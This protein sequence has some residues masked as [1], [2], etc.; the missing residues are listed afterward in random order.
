MEAL[1]FTLQFLLYSITTW[2]TMNHPTYGKMRTILKDSIKWIQIGVVLVGDSDAIIRI[3]F[4]KNLNVLAE[5]WDLDEQLTMNTAEFKILCE[6]DWTK[7]LLESMMKEIRDENITELISLQ[8]AVEFTTSP[9]NV[10]QLS[11]AEWCNTSFSEM[12]DK[13]TPADFKM[14]NTNLQDLMT[15]YD[16]GTI[17]VS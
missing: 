8:P 2:T 3:L 4:F 12:L 9:L 7:K 15:M 1:D 14:S 10:S 17:E 5:D 13:V 11:N 6:G 16:V